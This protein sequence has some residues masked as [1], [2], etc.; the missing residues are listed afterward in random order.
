MIFSDTLVHRTYGAAVP[1]AQG[2]DDYP[3]PTAGSVR[4][5]VQRPS[6]A[7]LIQF[8]SPYAGKRT[9]DMWFVDTPSVLKTADEMAARPADQVDIVDP[10]GV[11]R[12]YEVKAVQHVRGVIVHYEALVVRIEEAKQ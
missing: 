2:G 3:A 12:A 8:G 4:A 1:N 6:N 5:S 7:E 10:N 11:A 9:N